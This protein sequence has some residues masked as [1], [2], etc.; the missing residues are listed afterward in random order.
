MREDAPRVCH[1]DRI[2]CVDK[3]G[4][5]DEELWF[6]NVSHPNNMRRRLENKGNFITVS[7]AVKRSYFPAG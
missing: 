4:K 2:Y 7:T 5:K 1:F 6:L 3:K